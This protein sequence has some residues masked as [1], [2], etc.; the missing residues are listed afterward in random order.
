M[1][2]G[3]LSTI[4]RA[5][6]ILKTESTSGNAYFRD[7]FLRVSILERQILEIKAL[8]RVKHPHLTSLKIQSTSVAPLVEGI[9]GNIRK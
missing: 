8:I 9:P 3:L 7:L 1:F 2:S 6:V 4:Y 5:M